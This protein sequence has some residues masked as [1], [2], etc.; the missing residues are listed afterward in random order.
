MCVFSFSRFK[1]LLLPPLGFPLGKNCR[2]P[3]KRYYDPGDR[4][5]NPG[6]EGETGD[7]TAETNLV[8]SPRQRPS[9]RKRSGLS[10]RPHRAGWH[11][12]PLASR[13]PSAVTD[14]FFFSPGRGGHRKEKP[15]TS[16]SPKWSSKAGF[17]CIHFLSIGSSS[18]LNADNESST[19]QI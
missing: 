10:Q 9:V 2:S 3:R 5:W 18:T 7:P 19:W 6:R 1:S 12:T 13:P 17:F 16:S 15:F 11:R 8:L 4:D 14:F